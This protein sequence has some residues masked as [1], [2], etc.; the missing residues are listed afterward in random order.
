MSI[1][2]HGIDLVACGRVGE[3]CR[4][5]GDRFLERILT[6]GEIAYVR[7][8]RRL[9]QHVAGRFAAKEAILKVLGTGWRTRIS[10]KD[11]EILNDRLGKPEVRLSG[12]CARIAQ[13]LGIDRVLISI[14]H[15]GEYAL[16]SAIAV[17][18]D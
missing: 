3:I 2:A 14:S 13:N 9:Q 11:M 15:T 7:R 6:P 10:W 17:S 4:R 1:V 12:E 8:Q 16:A 18:A 5:H